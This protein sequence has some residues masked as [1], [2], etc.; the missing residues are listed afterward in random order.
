MT[1]EV[2]R[3][4]ADDVPRA[5]AQRAADA[6]SRGGAPPQV[7]PA[8][9]T[10]LATDLGP[11]LTLHGANGAVQ[12]TTAQLD[13]VMPQVPRAVL[14][15]ARAH[16]IDRVTWQPRAGVREAVIA[17]AWHSTT[18]QKV[19]VAGNSLRPSEDRQAQLLLLML[20]D[21]DDRLSGDDRGRGPMAEFG[22]TWPPE[23]LTF[24]F[25]RA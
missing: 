8:A 3:S 18:A 16:R 11:F 12:A 5:Q 2:T 19:V 17:L 15:Q 24:G 7:A 13:G 6:L 1:Q 20:A 9:A 4:S 14:A 25:A 10:D 23:Q 21:R 22:Q